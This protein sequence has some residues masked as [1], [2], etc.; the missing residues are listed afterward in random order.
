M[1]AWAVLPLYRALVKSWHSLL[2]SHCLDTVISLLCLMVLEPYSSVHKGLTFEI[3]SRDSFSSILPVSVFTWRRKVSR[4]DS[5][6]L[7][8]LPMQWKPMLFWDLQVYEAEC[9]LGQFYSLWTEWQAVEPGLLEWAT[10]AA[11][12]VT[13][14][15]VATEIKPLNFGGKELG[16][17]FPICMR[18]HTVSTA[19]PWNHLEQ[20]K[21]LV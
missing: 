8:N 20:V 16:S 19:N 7:W 17:N 21:C 4:G 2:V 18:M 6:Y 1:G 10:L 15:T 13:G 9:F 12:M 3:M 5:C 11:P 14:P